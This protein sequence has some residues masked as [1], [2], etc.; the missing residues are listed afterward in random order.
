M[1]SACWLEEIRVC[2]LDGLFEEFVLKRIAVY[3][4]G[5]NFIRFAAW[6]KERYEIVA[7]VDANETVW[8]QKR[9]GIEVGSPESVENLKYDLVVV[10]PNDGFEIVDT[11]KD[12]YRVPDNKIVV[13]EDLIYGNDKRGGIRTCFVLV[14]GLGDAIINYNY[15]YHFYGRFKDDGVEIDIANVSRAFM[16]FAGSGGF[17]RNFYGKDFDRSDYDLIIELR[18]YPSI[19]RADYF[20][21]GRVS[22]QLTEYLFLCRRFEIDNP[23][24][25]HF[26][27]KNDGAGADMEIKCGR[28]RFVQPDIN[29]ELGITEDYAPKVEVDK[30]LLKEYG[31]FDDKYI[32]IHRGCDRFFFTD[33]NV[34]LWEEEKYEELIG[35]FKTE[36]PGVKIVL[37]GEEY[38]RSDRIKSC[39][40]DLLGKTSISK[41]KAILK[42]SDLHVDTEGGLVHMRHAVGGGTSVVL[43]GPTSDKF[44]GY[45]ENVNIRTDACPEPCEWKTKDWAGNCSNTDD[46]HVCMRSITPQM[47]VSGI[48]ET[49][50]RN[51]KEQ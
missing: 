10:T 4:A 6:L 48:K 38:E 18:R 32:T 11:L 24:L 50:V 41:L 42:Y 33:E 26:G 5:G 40:I 13:L 3:G 20:R 28:T 9:E 12:T 34:K 43:F 45:S 47:V 23:E 25:I 8:G 30:E 36:Y 21:I 27:P 31:L 17:V 49:D 39:D 16:E 51:S 22:P 2:D 29:G 37:L 19:V 44:F 15:I 7:L 1:I 46:K 14:G 35:L